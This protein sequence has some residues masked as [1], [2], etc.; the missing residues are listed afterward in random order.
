MNHVQR[1]FLAIA[2]LL[3]AVLTGCSGAEETGEHRGSGDHLGISLAQCT[4]L[5]LDE[6]YDQVR[7]AARLI[8]VYDADSNSFTGTVQNTTEYTL[9]QVRVEVHLSNGV[10]LGP[11]TPTDLKA[12]ESTDVT[13][14]APSNGFDGWTA[15]PEVSEGAGGEQGGDGEG[16]HGGEGEGER[17]G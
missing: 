14:T 1:I 9:K 2:V 11:T 10:E 8:L 12:G 16:E 3:A 5:G 4:E 6:E 17:D 13:L 15:H 7:S